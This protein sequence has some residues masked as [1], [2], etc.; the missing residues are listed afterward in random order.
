MKYILRSTFLF[1]FMAVFSMFA[2]A[3]QV[4]LSS[5]IKDATYWVMTNQLINM[6]ATDGSVVNIEQPGGSPDT[7]SAI[8]AN[9]VSGGIVQ[10]DVLWLRSRNQDLTNLKT[11]MP[12][13]TEQ[14]HFIALG[15]DIKSGGFMGIGGDKITLNDV[16]NLKG[17]NVAASG[18]SVYTAQA[19]NQFSGLGYLVQ[20]DY[21]DTPAVLDAVRTGKVAAAVVVGGAP[22]TA[23]SKLS[24]EFRILPVDA[25]T[26]EKLKDVYRPK[27]VNYENLSSLGVPTV[28]TDALLVVNNYEGTK[29][30]NALLKLRDC[31]KENLVD[32]RENE[33]SHPAWRSVAK[34]TSERPRWDVYAS[35]KK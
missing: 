8:A 20:S 30:K 4:K 22:M 14:V 35:D 5:G 23:I 16:R 6:C 28:E 9:K 32:L 12:L 1:A 17:L 15:K 7:I 3:Q 18:G 29:M 24:R 21:K 33:G 26:A 27:S 19:I 13:H 25:Q 34:S 2:H 10:F 11:L 31:I